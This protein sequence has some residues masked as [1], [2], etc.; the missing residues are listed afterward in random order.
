MRA[1]GA[2]ESDAQH[3]TAERYP[4]AGEAIGTPQYRRA[5]ICPLTAGQPLEYKVLGEMDERLEIFGFFC[6]ARIAR[7][8]SI[9]GVWPRMRDC[10]GRR[11]NCFAVVYNSFIGC[12][13][14]ANVRAGNSKHAGNRASR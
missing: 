2:A 6:G 9:Q 13:A 12:G 7:P 14:R 8:A 11:E 5:C 10:V 4:N 3:K 1:Q